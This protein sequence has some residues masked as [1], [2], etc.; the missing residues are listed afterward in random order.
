MFC[1]VRLSVTRLFFLSRP[2]NTEESLWSSYFVN[3]LDVDLD[4][5]WDRPTPEGTCPSSSGCPTLSSS[6]DGP[7]SSASSSSVPDEPSSSFP[8]RPLSSLLDF[9]L[10]LRAGMFAGA[11]AEGRARRLLR[12]GEGL[13]G[14]DMVMPRL[15]GLRN[16][17]R[18][19]VTK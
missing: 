17:E 5:L 11:L 12:G 9:L 4:D 18:N 6:P 3:G 8:S 14:G 19:D 7:S 16:W 2:F 13:R 1:R 10:G 15:E